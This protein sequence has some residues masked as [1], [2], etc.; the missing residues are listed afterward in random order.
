[1]RTTLFAIAVCV[2]AG[3]G[4]KE[5]AKSS[6]PTTTTTESKPVEAKKASNLNGDPVDV[7]AQ[8]AKDKVEA[9][10][11]KVTREP[12]SL[13]PQDSLLGQCTWSLESGF[14]MVSARPA[15]EYEGTVKYAGDTKEV[16]GVGEKAA[17]APQTGFLVKVPG[18]QFLL[19]VI[20]TGDDDKGDKTASLAK[21]AVEQVK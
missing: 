8:M 3:C 7:C 10:V 1:M 16:A 18:K 6:S 4:K 17:F 5:E 20:V 13:Q 12:Q 19:Q 15:S 2:V 9:I 11:G 14:A 21:L